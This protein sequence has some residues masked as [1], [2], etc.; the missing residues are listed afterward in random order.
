M[1]SY[2]LLFPIADVGRLLPTVDFGITMPNCKREPCDDRPG[3]CTYI[4]QVQLELASATFIHPPDAENPLCCCLHKFDAVKR[5]AKGAS[6]FNTLMVNKQ[7]T[8]EIVCVKTWTQRSEPNEKCLSAGYD[9]SGEAVGRCPSTVC[10][11]DV[12]TNRKSMS[13]VYRYEETNERVYNKPPS[14]S[15]WP[16]CASGEGQERPKSSSWW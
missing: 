13:T 6:R 2:V 8:K 4:E 1:D 14:C 11:C 5:G 15:R 10:A 9:S 12:D 16:L 7:C 3:S